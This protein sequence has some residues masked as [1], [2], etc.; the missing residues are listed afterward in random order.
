[1]DLSRMYDIGGCRCV[2]PTV[3]EANKVRAIFYDTH[4]PLI[5][6]EMNYIDKPK[7]DGYRSIHIIFNY[8]DPD[9]PQYKNLKI[10]MQLRSELQHY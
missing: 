4:R 10:E 1:M 7:P 8:D 6:K 9:F 2:F 3:D 5:C